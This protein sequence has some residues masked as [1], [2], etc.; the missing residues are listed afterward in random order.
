MKNPHLRGLTL[1]LFTCISGKSALAVEPPA[2]LPTPETR[3]FLIDDQTGEELLQKHGIHPIKTLDL[4]VLINGVL[5]H[6]KPVELLH[7]A[8]DEDASD[9]PVSRLSFTPYSGEKPPTPPSP[10]LPLRQ[11]TN[12]MKSYLAERSAWQKGILAYRELLL[13]AVHGFTRKVMATQADVAQR[14]DAL[15]AARNGRDFNRSD[16]VGSVLTA[17]Q[18]LGQSGKRVLVLNTDAKDLPG[19]R[20]PRR[21]SLTVEE[22]NP[23]VEI[24]W[25]NTSGIPNLSQLFQG[26]SNRSHHVAS[27]REAM[28]LVI[29]LIDDTAPQDQDSAISKR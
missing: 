3:V 14:F 16:I 15:L 19:K 11:L 7:Q 24:V 20:R 13:E 5:K 8:I 28:E 12:A 10:N 2:P 6:G 17:N 9:N 26:L 4:E 22:L 1:A 25:V 18:L 23:E 29:T 27:M 21:N